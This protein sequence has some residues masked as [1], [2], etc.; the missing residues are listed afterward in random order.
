MEKLIDLLNE[1]NCK[2]KKYAD[3]WELKDSQENPWT[4]FIKLSSVW[5]W[6]IYLYMISKEYWFI[7]WLV[8]DLRIDIDKVRRYWYITKT[9]DLDELWEWYS[10]IDRI[11]MLLAISDEPVDLLISILK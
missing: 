8:H 6:K 3:K 11:L 2:V 10:Y 1:Y 9:Y 7:E 5:A 4:K